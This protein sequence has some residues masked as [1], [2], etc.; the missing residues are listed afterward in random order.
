MFRTYHH[1]APFAVTRWTNLYFKSGVGGLAG[2]IVAGPVAPL[3][4]PLARAHALLA[5]G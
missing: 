2:D 5:R 1:A 3:F 4:G